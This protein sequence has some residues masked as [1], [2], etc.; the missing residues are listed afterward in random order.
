[1]YLSLNIEQLFDVFFGTEE[2][3]EIKTSKI[4]K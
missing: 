1:M 4:N 3:P 2:Q